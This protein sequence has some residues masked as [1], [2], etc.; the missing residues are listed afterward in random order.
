MSRV[1]WLIPVRDRREWLG[2]A[3]RSVLA[4]SGEEDEVWVIDDGSQDRPEQ[5]LPRDS[6]LRLIQQPARGIV[7]A[8]ERGRFE[9]SG[10]YL[11][12]LD[13]D[14]YSCPGRVAAQVAA[15]DAEP[16]LSAVGG[17]V[18]IHPDQR[19]PAEG[20]RRYLAWLNQLRDPSRELLVESPLAHPAVMM[21]ARDVD[22][23]GGYRDFQGPEDYDLW[24]RLVQSGGGIRNLDLEVVWIRDHGARLTRVDARYSLAAFRRTRWTLFA[25][26]F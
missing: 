21:R 25:L 8:L 1:S 9:A 11:A 13:S 2:E 4:D 17:R 19:L 22:K 20:M 26:R 14:D 6:R 23:V 18:G 16:G 3:V 10:Q 24:L 15:L 12:R 7:A 5:V